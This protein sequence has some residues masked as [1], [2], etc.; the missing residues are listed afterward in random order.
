MKIL[1][2]ANT[3]WYLY[4]FRLGLAKALRERGDQVVLVSPD[5]DY[6][7]RLQESGFRWVCFPMAPH[8]MNPLVEISTILRLLWLY[9]R[10]KPDLVHH[11]T[12]KCVL[13]GSWVSHLIGIRR[14]VNSVTGLGFV[15]IERDSENLRLRGLIKFLYRLILNRTWVIFQN[16]SDKNLFLK[17]RLVKEN[18][19]SIIQ[20]SGVDT[21]LFSPQPVLDGS[22]LVILP[23]RLLW[24]KGVGEF[25]KA[26]RQLKKDGIDARFALVG[27]TDFKNPA[28]I[29][30]EQIK[31]WVGE[32]VVESWGWMDKMVEVYAQ[33]HIVCLPSY[34][35]GTSKTLVEAAACGRPLITCDVPGCREVVQLGING[36]LVSPRDVQGLVGAM[37]Y[38]I[39]NPDER[40]I[41]GNAG[42]KIA[43]NLFSMDLII[44][45]T[46]TVYELVQSSQLKREM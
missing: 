20:G 40:K 23:A 44:S 16:T 25:V 27:D 4:N 31:V 18:K 2:F 19:I 36:L 5:G 9:L 7:I 37:R 26:A 3:D 33:A 42:R 13:Y 11:F 1:L 45:Q 6:S 28:G 34:R 17:Y 22:P 29:P 43:E 46:F 30:A 35:E 38:L 14:V 10:E 21:K 24:D 41:M 39:E 8:G 15:F 32:G 12:I